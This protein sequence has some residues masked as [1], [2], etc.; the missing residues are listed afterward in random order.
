MKKI[1]ILSLSIVLILSCKSKL[2]NGTAKAGIKAPVPVVIIPEKKIESLFEKYAKLTYGMPYP[3][4]VRI[5]EKEGKLVSFN[6][7]PGPGA[8]PI[9]NRLFDWV[10]DDEQVISIMFENG[11]LINKGQEGLTKSL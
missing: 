2:L 4:V 6:D 10:Y 11:V 3:N 5:L 1:L 7:I 8:R 9:E